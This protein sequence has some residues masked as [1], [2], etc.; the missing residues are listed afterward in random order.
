MSSVT[1]LERAF[2]LARSGEHTSVQSIRAR[3]KGEGFANVEAHL[4]GHSIS[5]QLRKICL[6]ARAGSPEPTA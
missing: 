1:I 6:E 3:L 2:A 5:R 4:S